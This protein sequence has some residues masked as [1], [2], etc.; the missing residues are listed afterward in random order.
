MDRPRPAARPRHAGPGH[1]RGARRERLHDAPAARRA[2]TCGGRSRSPSP[3]RRATLY[4]TARGVLELAA[5]RHARRRRRAGARLD[6]LPRADRVRRPRRHRAAARRARTCSARS[7]ATA[8]TR[9]SSASTRAG[10]AITTA[11]TRSCCASCTSSTTTAAATIVAVR[12]AAGRAADRADRLLRPADG[13]A[14][15]RAARARR[16]GIPSRRCR[17]RDASVRLVPERAQPI[18]VT[19]DLRAGRGHGSAAPASTSST[20]ARTWS[21]GC[22]CASQGER[23]TRVQLRFAEMLEPDGSL[24]LANLRGAPPAR[25]LRAGRRRRRGLGAALHVPRLPLRRG[26]GHRRLR[27]DRP[28]RALRHAAQRLVRVL[29]RARQPALAQHQLGPARQLRLG[30]DRLPAARRAPR[31]ARRRAGLP[32]HRER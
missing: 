18:R 30:P 15:R 26:H 4:A 24:H 29:G 5:Q 2:R 20:S 6:R 1:R 16:R 13:R 25:H 7:S 10:P 22:G 14:L 3:V 32:P 28:R 11:A 12:R 19:E 23:G 17:P 8:G 21:A 27:A 9:A 31:L